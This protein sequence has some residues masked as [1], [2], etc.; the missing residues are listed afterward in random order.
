MDFLSA[1]A[2]EKLERFPDDAIVFNSLSL[3]NEATPLIRGYGY[4]EART[5]M[6]NDPA[7]EKASKTIAEFIRSEEGLRHQSM[8]A[9]YRPYKDVNAWLTEV[10]KIPAS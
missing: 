5:W 4:R 3:M 7:G 9:L 10:A 6:D 1:L 8:N 2:H